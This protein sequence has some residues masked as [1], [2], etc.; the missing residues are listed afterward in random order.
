ME[1]FE[2]NIAKTI[3]N[4]SRKQLP[5][6]CSAWI[7]LFGR[8]NEDTLH[9]QLEAHYTEF[10]N[11]IIKDNLKTEE[12]LLARLNGEDSFV[13]MYLCIFVSMKSYIIYQ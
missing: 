12:K 10:L 2:Q 8:K 3:E 4:I 9:L 7:R 13:S 5:K 11:S 1:A 6:L